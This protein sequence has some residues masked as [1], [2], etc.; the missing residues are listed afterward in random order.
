MII[1]IKRLF[2]SFSRK[3]RAALLFA[4]IICV[5]STVTLGAITLDRATTSV[6]AHG[7]DYIEGVIE[8]PAYINPVLAATDTDRS[9]V[10]L[11]FSNIPALAEKIE[12]SDENR[13]W[14]VRLKENLTWHNGIKLT[15]DD[16][17]FTI[18][19]IQDPESRSPLALSWQG[20]SVRRVSELEFTIYLPN[21]YAFFS[22]NLKNL[23]VIPKHL[24]ADTPVSNWRLAEYNLKPIGSG[25]YKFDSFTQQSDGFIETYRLYAWKK[26]DGS[27]P[28][29][30][31]FVME[32][33]RQMP[34]AVKAFN[35]GKIDGIAGIETSTINDIKRPYAL[36]AF[37]MPSYYAIFINQARNGALKDPKVRK[38]LADAVSRDDIITRAMSGF[39]SPQEKV[40]ITTTFSPDTNNEIS[41]SSTTP[42]NENLGDLLDAAGW[43]IAS[44]SDARVKIEGRSSSTLQATLVV[45]QI[46]FLITTAELIRD[47]W[48]KIGVIVTL[49]I[50]HPEDI[51]SS[52]IK[53]RNYDML[54]FGNTLNPS[55]DLFPFWHSS[56]RF[57]PGLNISL[58]NN[59]KVDNLIES[60]RENINEDNRTK[61]I[62]SIA[63]IIAND[64][65]AIFLYSPKYLTVTAKNVGGIE[66]TNTIA[67]PPERFE[68]VSDW[69]VKT[70]RVLK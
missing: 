58:Y 6:P 67:N 8:Q 14:S 35:S 63:A 66:T 7:G 26:P 49:D 24:F 11:I 30:T 42:I 39:A 4:A 62:D 47:A 36:H 28:N 56:Q 32:F 53:D 2:S 25:P 44:S 57:H 60:V 23:Y 19:K 59:K 65:P 40:S 17:I 18:Q 43:H 70:A 10:H 5:S 52:A 22:E 29:I 16:I 21:P 48:K 50:A 64:T 55:D 69:Y 15:S 13:T 3:E 20:I 12:A 31:T 41:S 1:L 34:D 61:D 45:P 37:T 27:T 46:P 38:I 54:L 9:L 68:N 33:F 51:V